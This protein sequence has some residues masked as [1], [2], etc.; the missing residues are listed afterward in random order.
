MKMYYLFITIMIA[1]ILCLPMKATASIE[2][3]IKETSEWIAAYGMMFAAHEYGHQWQADELNVPIKWS[4][5]NGSPRWTT[6]YTKDATIVEIRSFD[7]SAER[8]NYIKELLIGEACKGISNCQIS[9]KLLKAGSNKYIIEYPNA[10]ELLYEIPRKE[11]IIAG[12]GFRGQQVAARL[13]EGKQLQR[14]YL[15]TSAFNKISYAV[16]PH[17]MQWFAAGKS[18]GDVATFE[19]TRA[20]LPAQIALYI[21][22]A[23][24]LWKAYNGQGIGNWSLDFWQSENGA[25]GLILTMKF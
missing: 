25:P 8:D 10:R 11:A 21:S 18:G 24:D 12:A 14:K 16:V 13:L 22:G 19:R 23:S 4:F 2:S 17:G 1:F 20:K 5:N 15:V 6:D 9:S 3:T 7:S